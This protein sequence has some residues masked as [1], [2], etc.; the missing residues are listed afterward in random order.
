[1][2]HNLDITDGVASFA[3]ARKDAWHQLG[4]VVPEEMTAL[5]V[6]SH[7]HLAGWNVRK[8]PALFVDEVTGE[9][10]E[11]TERYASIRT[12]PING[13]IDYLGD[14]GSRYTHTQNEAHVELLD[15][16]VDESGAH[17]S[18]AGALNGGRRVFVT[19]KMPGHI[20]IGG[21]D[22]V[23]NYIA[24]V[25]S[26]DGSTPFIIMTTPV[27]IV[28]ENTL[29]MAFGSTSNVF[30]VRHTTNS[31]KAVVARAREVLD[32]T[33]NY[34]EGF[35]Q[36]AEALINTTVTQGQFEEL[37]A[38]EFG[39]PDDAAAKTITMA[40]KRIEILSE[41]FSDASTHK[42]VRNTAWAALNAFT[43]F[44]D[45]FAAA[46]GDDREAKLAQRAILD[47]AFKNNALE[48]VKREFCLL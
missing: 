7:A 33:F 2:A 22:E 37:I 29:N 21:V 9:L 4:Q 17:F 27:R 10:R 20:K 45:H 39:A 28:C 30:R 12:N 43:E 25:N 34:L 32:M 23:N 38:R 31:H 48:L 42:A 16:L 41:L 35:Q 24:A 11:M 8:T 14:V 47:P 44:A 18:T 40:D 5:E 6:L 3:S 1:M 36:E 46:R 19:M 15:A 13:G 26:H